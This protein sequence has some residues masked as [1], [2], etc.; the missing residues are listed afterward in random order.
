MFAKHSMEL[1][2]LRL[3]EIYDK[4]SKKWKFT[5]LETYS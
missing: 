1:Y 4:I 2:I 3:K 5:N